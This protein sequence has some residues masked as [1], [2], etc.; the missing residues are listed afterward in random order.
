MAKSAPVSASSGPSDGALSIGIVGAGEIVRTIHLPVLS[1][2]EGVRLAY[3]ADKN[4]RAAD[5]LAKTFRTSA[6]TVSEDADELPPADVVLLAVP[7]AARTRYYE[8]FAN[9][10][11]AVLAE[12]PLATSLRDAQRACALFPDFALACGFQRRGYATVALARTLIAENWFGPLRS[13]SIAEGALTTKTGV[14]SR[15]Y[16]EGGSGGGVLMDLGC[17]SLDIAL[18]I[19][20]A[21]SVTIERQRFVMD[22]EVDREIEAQMILQT[23][24]GACALDY[25]VSWLQPTENLIRLRFDNCVASFSVRPADRIEVRGLSDSHIA[26]LSANAAGA[27]TIYQAFY[28]EWKAFLR[29]VRNHEPSMFSAQSALPTVAAVEALYNARRSCR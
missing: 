4:S 25:L 7:A 13:I 28:L 8:L 11:A 3:I 23:L 29:G 22:G 27:S 1:S 24:Q 21:T 18:F 2:C 5:F 15:F 12:K 14:D 26:S 20:G 19:S 17:H 9:R 16:D 10:G 6:V